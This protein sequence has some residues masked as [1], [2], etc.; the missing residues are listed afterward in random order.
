MKLKPKSFMPIKALLFSL[1]QITISSLLF[2]G[3]TINSPINTTKQFLSYWQK[4]QYNEAFNLF[5]KT[6]SQEEN[7]FK[8]E[9]FSPSEKAQLIEKT[10]KNRGKLLK[11]NVQNAIPLKDN[12][13]QQLN[14]TEGYK[15]FF[16]T[17]TEKEGAKN[18]EYFVLK[19]DNN[20]RLLPSIE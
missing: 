17:E 8:I 1:S 10:K 19:V 3:C 9:N 14:I 20:W 15:V 4:E 18:N 6:T 5:V 13:L 2:A 16:Y 12:L 7:K 11:F